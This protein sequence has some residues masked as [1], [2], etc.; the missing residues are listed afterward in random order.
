MLDC[1]AVSYSLSSTTMIKV[2]TMPMA[3]LPARR[4]ALTRAEEISAEVVFS[5]SMITTVLAA[6]AGVRFAHAFLSRSPPGSAVP[7]EHL[8]GVGR[9][10]ATRLVVLWGFV[11]AGPVVQHGVE[12][13][14]GQLDFLVV[15]EQWRISEQDVENEPFVRL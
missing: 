2:S 14:P 13:L 3:G 5:N 12:D 8:V 10:P 1:R 9:P 6:R 7:S 11:Q 15:R 4:R